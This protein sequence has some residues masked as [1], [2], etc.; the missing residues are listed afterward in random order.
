MTQTNELDLAFMKQLIGE[1]MKAN[2]KD[3]PDLVA[4]KQSGMVV[5][6]P[7]WRLKV[8]DGTAYL[9]NLNPGVFG[10]AKRAVSIDIV[11]AKSLQ[12]DV[13]GET[14]IGS[15]VK[16]SLVIDGQVADKKFEIERSM[17]DKLQMQGIAS[18]AAMG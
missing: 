13:S 15:K 3:S 18:A 17:L 16:C 7:E 12:L 9:V 4:M 10:T 6:N 5:S 2:P 14:W 11:P 8:V 1:M